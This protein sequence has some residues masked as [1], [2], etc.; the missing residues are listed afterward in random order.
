[1][2]AGTYEEWLRDNPEPDLQALVLKH[3]GYGWVPLEAWREFDFA[4]AAWQVKRKLRHV[5]ERRA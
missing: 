2:T 5:E 3:G 4:I 1:M